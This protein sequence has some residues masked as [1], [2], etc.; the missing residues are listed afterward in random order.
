MSTDK[1]EEGYSLD[2]QEEKGI[3]YATSRGET[4]KVYR[5]IESGTSPKRLDRIKKDIQAK[6][7]D[8]LWIIHIDRLTRLS[9]V[10]AFE[11]REYLLLHR[12]RVIERDKE[13]D[14]SSLLNFGV[15]AL[16]NYDY[17]E[18]LRLKTREAKAAQRNAGRQTYSSLYGYEQTVV[19]S[20]KN[21]KA[22]R[23]WVINPKKAKV[24]QLIFELNTKDRLGL[25]EIC[26]RVNGMGYKSEKG[27]N[28][29]PSAISRILAH[30][31]YTGKSVDKEGRII[32]GQVYAP[33]IDF[34]T[35]EAAQNSYVPTITNN[36][37][38]GRI[39][40][41]AM[42]NIL[43]CE[44]CGAGFYYHF[45]KSPYK[46]KH[47]DKVTIRY[48]H[49]YYHRHT[50]P[51]KNQRKSF[52][53]EV[54]DFIGLILYRRSMTEASADLLSEVLKDI[55][56]RLEDA[57]TLLDNLRKELEIKQA[58]IKN[59]EGAIAKG[60]GIEIASV[61]INRRQVEAEA[62]KKRMAE[63]EEQNKAETQDYQSILAEFSL[64]KVLEYIE[65][66]P[67][68]RL[69]MLKRILRKA[70][71]KDGEL[72]FE[73][74]DGR[75]YQ[76]SYKAYQAKFKEIVSTA[77]RILAV[78]PKK[79]THEG[80]M[81]KLMK[82]YAPP[83]MIDGVVKSFVSEDESNNQMLEQWEF[84]YILTSYLISKAA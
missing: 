31:E 11:F 26:K 60:L 39:A 69:A 7:I 16:V 20:G 38:R 37:K 84:M 40:S 82:Y 66:S 59:F 49:L 33:I 79:K 30:I 34:A 28:F 43:H 68:I 4:Y 6:K 13:F 48:R 58:E 64:K 50:V 44:Y 3:A 17:I 36:S 12:I 23:E 18:R 41:H 72:M 47:S 19:G 65:A 32:E 56:S 15:N 14:L 22:L 55:R 61:N 71:T 35:W 57:N 77:N 53:M 21:G 83:C 80:E 46:W 54:L 67:K 2:L 70:T 76:F 1:Q 63:V 24:V 74:I 27:I 8:A 52:S 25:A 73:L 29:E 78:Y 9:P 51:C 62:I 81:E 75:S 45:G 10:L 5:D 42:T